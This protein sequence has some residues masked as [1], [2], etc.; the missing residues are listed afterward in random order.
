MS[1][2]FEV[3]YKLPAD[4]A[5]DE[6]ITGVVSRLG[7]SLGF[8]EVSCARG[9]EV[10]CLTYEFDELDSARTAADSLRLRGEHV[11]GP[12]DYGE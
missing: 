4:P 6:L 7:G 12:V 11:E 2:M 5:K 3:Y 10:I 9:T 8:R 1:F